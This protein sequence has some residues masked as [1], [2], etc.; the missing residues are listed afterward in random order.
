MNIFVVSVTL[1]F[2]LANWLRSIAL[3]YTSLIL[4]HQIIFI[5]VNKGPFITSLHVFSSNQRS[6]RELYVKWKNFEDTYLRSVQGCRL[7]FSYPSKIFQITIFQFSFLPAFENIGLKSIVVIKPY[8]GLSSKL[9][10][11]SML[12]IHKVTIWKC[13]VS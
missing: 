7:V 11:K 9:K 13:I 3:F 12:E 2:Q 10:R 1:T 8:K 4:H 6:I 5:Q